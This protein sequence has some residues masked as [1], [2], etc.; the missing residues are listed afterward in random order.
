MDNNT[1][2]SNDN[3]KFIDGDS[4]YRANKEDDFSMR[5]IIMGQV[6]NVIAFSNCEHRGGY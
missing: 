3:M 4:G 6:K 2:T 1:T 5:V